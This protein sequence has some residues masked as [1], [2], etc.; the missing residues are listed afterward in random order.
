LDSAI[1]A[2]CG[3]PVSVGPSET[4]EVIDIDNHGLLIVTDKA[5]YRFPETAAPRVV[6]GQ[7][8]LAGSQLVYGV[9]V[10]EFF[11]GNSY[12]R[13]A[14]Q[15]VV[16]CPPP[17]NALASNAWE[18]LAT[19]ADEDLL[20]DPNAE[21]CVPV[22]KT[23]A[24]LALD[25]GFLSSCFYGDLV[26]E[27]KDVPLQVNTAHP[28]GYTY[29]QFQL[30]G[31]PAD[32]AQF[33]DEVH[34]RGITAYEQQ[35]QAQADCAPKLKRG[36]LAHLLDKR[37]NSATEPTESNLPKTINPLRFLIENVLRNNVFV[38][39]ISVSALGLNRLGLYNV[40][41]L[42]QLLPPQTAMIVIF[43]LAA[44]KDNITPNLLA[45]TVAFFTGMDPQYDEVP[46][47]LVSDL[48]TTA[49][50]VSGNCQ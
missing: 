49:R 24:A 2:I 35:Q 11:V 26:F 18:S 29:V 36:T 42:R 5:S 34:V 30:G 19:E 25:S 47:N 20:L 22:R 37:V 17:N 28:S 21:Q 12:L 15:S 44:D 43:E 27:N 32:V 23:I 41:Y 8:I 48:G 13:P 33:F 38:V 39:R 14:D 6:V 4:V 16:C 7:T 31:H 50:L 40:R 9:D 1:A 45:E 3:V 10:H 46:V